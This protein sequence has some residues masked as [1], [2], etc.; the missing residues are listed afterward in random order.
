MQLL[1]VCRAFWENI[2]NNPFFSSGEII[3][4]TVVCQINRSCYRRGQSYEQFVKAKGNL[5]SSECFDILICN[6]VA[7]H[8]GSPKSN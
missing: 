5:A 2:P 4:D 7:L 8:K 3:L 1:D 6:L